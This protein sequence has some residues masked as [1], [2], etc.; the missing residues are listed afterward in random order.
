L[1]GGSIA[2]FLLRGMIVVVLTGLTTCAPPARPRCAA[3]AGSPMVI[4]TLYLGKAIPGRSDLTDK[5][6]RTFL[7]DT[8]TSNLPNG[9][10]V[11]DGNGGWMNPITRKT[12]KEA[13]KILVAALPDSADSLAAIERIRSAYQLRFRQQLVGMTAEQACGT[14]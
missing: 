3:G 10:T 6:W 11:L 1:G 8:V 5:E 7:D 2:R 9:F 14:F 13:T 4:F 12:I